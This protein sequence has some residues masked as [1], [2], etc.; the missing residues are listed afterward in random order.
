MVPRNSRQR[1]EWQ[2]SFGYVPRLDPKFLKSAEIWSAQCLKKHFQCE[3]ARL[4]IKH[5]GTGVYRARSVSTARSEL[6]GE[7]Q[8]VPPMRMGVKHIW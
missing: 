3:V 2:T 8:L 4:V 6:R 1:R 5:A 7:R